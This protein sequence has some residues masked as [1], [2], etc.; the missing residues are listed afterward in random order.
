MQFFASVKTTH[1]K[2]LLFISILF[3]LFLI[4]FTYYSKSNNVVTPEDGSVWINEPRLSP[5]SQPK[6]I[7]AR[8]HLWP[9]R[10]SSHAFTP[11]SSLSLEGKFQSPWTYWLLTYRRSRWSC[12]SACSSKL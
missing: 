9:C 4:I 1:I 2:F 11:G 6:R 5:V 8:Q 7:V 10:A 12:P 3:V